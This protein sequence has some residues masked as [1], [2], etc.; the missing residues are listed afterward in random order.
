L[1]SEIGRAFLFVVSRTDRVELS[2][3]PLF[4]AP[5]RSRKLIV[6]RNCALQD[7][8]KILE[9]D[10]DASEEAIRSSYVRLA[11]VSVYPVLP[12]APYLDRSSITARTVLLKMLFTVDC[13]APRSL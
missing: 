8:Y 12:T 2:I 13:T 6:P 5:R 10:F 11:L 3:I 9:V 7:Y 1:V 4:R